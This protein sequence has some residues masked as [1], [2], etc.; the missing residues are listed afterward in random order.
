MFKVVFSAQYYPSRPYKI[1]EFYDRNMTR[2]SVPFVGWSDY[3]ITAM[4]KWD[5][6]PLNSN[7][8][9][10]HPNLDFW[11]VG[12]KIIAGTEAPFWVGYEFDVIYFAIIIVIK[13]IKLKLKVFFN[14]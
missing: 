1:W 7:S 5:Q 2:S 13:K 14:T 8:A 10:F 4:N 12:K 6:I 9:Q 3:N 11:K